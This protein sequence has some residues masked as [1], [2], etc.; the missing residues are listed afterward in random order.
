[1]ERGTVQL[2]L[3]CLLG[4]AGC[5]WPGRRDAARLDEL[6]ARVA[7]LSLRV[8]TIERVNEE[9]RASVEFVGKLV[10]EMRYEPV[11]QESL[12]WADDTGRTNALQG[13]PRYW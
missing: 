4:L 6:S 5:V 13:F 3:L 12:L 1:V 9:W 8:E 10:D 11:I 7:A 2:L